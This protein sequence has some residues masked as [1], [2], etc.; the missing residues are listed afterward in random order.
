VNDFQQY[1]IDFE[2]GSIPIGDLPIGARVVDPS[3]VW[4]FRPGE[5]Y[6]GNGEMKPV[7]W[8]VVA[9]DHYV[10]LEPHVTL[11]A[12]ELIG[13]HPFDNSTNRDPGL[14]DMHGSNH[15]GDSGTTNANHGLRPWLNS[16]GIH[17][18]EGFHR[19]FSESFK[20]TVLPTTMPNKEWECG[21]AYSTQ[22]K[23]FIPSTAELGDSAHK[24]TY[25]IGTAYAIFTNAGDTKRVALHDGETWWYW[26]RSPASTYGILVCLVNRHGGFESNFAYYGLAAVRPALNLKSEV[27]VSEIKD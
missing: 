20:Q 11:L 26:T 17:S 22:D 10:G 4:E 27:L 15:W 9:R 13:K 8:I 2:K 19:A 14:L 18:G 12:E 5:N 23:V 3:W 7:I 21:S 25:Q 24:N 6:S 16:T 1:K